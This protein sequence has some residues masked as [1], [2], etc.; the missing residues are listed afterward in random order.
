[1]RK[2]LS[3]FMCVAMLLSLCTVAGYAV[4]KTFE[5]S[6]VEDLKKL[7]E[8]DS[9]FSNTEVVLIND[10]TVNDGF[11]SLDEKNNPLYNGSSELPESF[12]PIERFKG[13]F[14]GQGYTISGLSLKSSLF[15]NCNDAVIK[16]L[17]VVNSL[18]VDKTSEA[19]A[20]ICSVAEKT[21]FENIYIDSYII[22]NGKY[23]G[24]MVG[25]A[26]ECIAYACRNENTIIGANAGGLFGYIGNSTISF[27]YNKASVFGDKSAGG[28]AINL[29]D[30]KV[31]DCY[32]SGDVIANNIDGL[33]G[34]F[35]CHIRGLDKDT[36]GNTIKYCYTA[37]DVIG[38]NTGKLCGYYVGDIFAMVRVYYE[39][40]DIDNLSDADSD[41][42]YKI[43]DQY[44]DYK[45]YWELSHS[46]V[47]IQDDYMERLNLY[48]V[49]SLKHD[50]CP[51]C[52]GFDD[53]VG[54][55]NGSNRGYPQLTMFHEHVWGD[56]KCDSAGTETAKCL[57]YNCDGINTRSHEHVFGEY[58]V[59]EDKLTETGVCACGEKDTR[60]H[61]HVFGDYTYNNDA[62]CEKNGTMTAVCTGKN[63]GVKD[64]V[65][66]P[67]H[68][69]SGH[70]FGDYVLDENGLTET[71]HCKN[72]GCEKT[73]TIEHVHSWG[74]YVYNN[75][76]ECEKDGTMTAHCTK[77]GCKATDTV[78]DPNHK[79]TGHS[80]G[81]WKSNGDAKFFKNGTESRVCEHCGIT[82]TRVA[83]RSAKIIVIFDKVVD[84]IFGL[85]K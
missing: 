71:A 40:E 75:D 32:N 59:N 25:N 46:G 63:C 8:L 37:G 50:W 39:G 33:A 30:C 47:F 53:Y 67:N 18:V 17:N 27:C 13:V 78:K 45:E 54:D 42:G 1:M 48:K 61:T 49:D 66:D 74:E 81:E 9:D 3:I 41:D 68:K 79:A 76:A 14:D 60:P 22:G 11:F 2:A 23:T 5:V 56:Y 26:K 38:H 16:N 73:E 6:S 69:A 57:C 85:F 55:A 21:K 10:I 52:I 62:D 80:F 70:N 58:I 4:D 34:G 64:T 36:Y 31:S 84:F 83:E 28:L 19:T 24:G 12:A 51:E 35:A 77:E 7:S 29:N 82:Q 43:I 44:D 20:M 72:S 65:N 15:E